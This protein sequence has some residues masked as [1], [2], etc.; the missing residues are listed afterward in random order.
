MCDNDPRFLTE[1]DH[2]RAREIWAE[3]YR[4]LEAIKAEEAGTE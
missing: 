1:A 2:A 4:R 3:T